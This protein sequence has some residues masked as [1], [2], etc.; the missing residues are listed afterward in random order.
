MRDENGNLPDS[1]CYDADTMG[2]HFT[3]D[4]CQKWIDFLLTHTKQEE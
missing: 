3:N 4:A 2:L 1:Y